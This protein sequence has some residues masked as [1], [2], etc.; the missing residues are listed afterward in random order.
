MALV[1]NSPIL[2]AGVLNAPYSSAI[3][4][5]GGVA[6]YTV[7]IISGSLPPGLSLKGILP[8][9]ETETTSLNGI[10][11]VVLKG[12]P[13]QLGVATLLLEVSDSTPGLPLTGVQSY[14]MTVSDIID[15]S[16]VTVDQVEFVTQLQRAL[17]A[18]NTWSTG[19]TS[20][21]SQTLI[22]LI[23][24]I[25][26]FATG[27]LVR[28]REDA[29]PTTAQS[30]SAIFAIADMLG[31]RL[32][33]ALPAQISVT[34]ASPTATT[35]PPFTQMNIGAYSWFNTEQIVLQASSVPVTAVLRQGTVKTFNINGLGTNLQAWVSPDNGFAVSDQDVQVTLNGLVLN[36]V[37][38]L[39][40][41]YQSGTTEGNAFVDRTMAD[42]SLLIQFGSGG[43]GVV[44]RVN[45]V[46]G[47]TYATTEG[48]KL[49]TVVLAQSPT[50]VTGFP[51]VTGRAVSN[52][53]GGANKKSATAYKNFSAGTFGTFGSAV[54]KSQ[55]NYVANS[56]PSVVDAI[57]MAQRDIN[58]SAYAWMNVIRVSALTTTNW[59]GDEISSYLDF[60][61][62]QTMY[63]T[64]FVWQNP[65]AV[66]RDVQVSVYFFNSVP[67]LSAGKALVTNAITKMFAPRP[68]ILLTNFYASDL[69]DAVMNAVPGQVS[70]VTIDTPTAPM[71]VTSPESPQAVATVATTGGTLAQESYSYAVSVNTPTPNEN[72]QSLI[73]ASLAPA[74][75]TATEPGQ[76]WI[77]S[78]AGTIGSFSVGIGD[79]LMAT[80][81][82]SSAG[83]FVVYP[84]ATNGAI[85]VGVPTNWVFP[86]VIMTG[87]TITLDWGNDQIP[88]A[89]Q[90]FV[91][92]RTSQN[93]GMMIELSEAVTRWTDDGSIVVSPTPIT[94]VF[95]VPIRYNSLGSLTVLPHYASRQ[96]S[97]TFP[98]R[99]TLS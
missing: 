94:S 91:W 18:T 68:G 40:W 11:D 54:T 23:S 41:N 7:A 75:P 27:R 19:I 38:G 14:T 86:Q 74:L 20:S 69:V 79:Q 26:T 25:G 64:K 46:V 67:S 30:D 61:Q 32:S 12:T 70:Y 96:Q 83:N 55:Y 31:V 15:L 80:S 84:A 52:P 78:Y 39:L 93:L 6:P 65:I 90:Y 4:I 62:S 33:R 34:L 97:A 72:F 98:V 99:D 50:T 8:V 57:T 10:I 59:T 21:T 29:F 28:V 88:N 17:A 73:N 13:T 71:V 56:Y 1:F 66:I 42:G 22:D 36:K 87:S 24:A 60:L 51:T 95:A 2:P 9:T 16:S 77:A 5:S 85:D 89:I 48:A 37:F 81:P 53:S 44:P 58:P 76:Y 3:G 82:G 92:G 49:N 47:I 63:S 43:Y 35:I 45:D